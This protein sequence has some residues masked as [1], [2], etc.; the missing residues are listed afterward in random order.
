M[1][2]DLER[3]AGRK[4]RNPRWFGGEFLSGT[5]AAFRRLNPYIQACW[6]HYLEHI[7]R[8]CHTGDEIVLSAALNLA[9]EDGLQLLDF[10]GPR[11][12]IIRWWTARTPFPQCSF[13]VAREH[14][15]LHLPS[16][17][18]FLAAYARPFSPAQFLRDYE[19]YARRKLVLRRIVNGVDWLRGG[20]AKH[21]ARV[22][23]GRSDR[24]LTSPSD[25]SGFRG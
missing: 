5:T 14:A 13:D 23:S 15:V 24:S 25:N 12:G 9:N 19:R 17:K 11:R 4:L 8:L 6:P 1:I 22:D 20:A 16:D 7:G 21:V 18:E 2:S 3:V 10:G